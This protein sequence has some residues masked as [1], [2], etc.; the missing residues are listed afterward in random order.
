MIFSRLMDWVDARLPVTEAYK[1]HMSE[2]YAPKN[3]NFWYFF[4][5]IS[6]FVLVNQL[7]TG[8]WLAMF[9]TPT[10]GF[11]SIA[12]IMRDVPWGWLIR[13][14]HAVG[15]SAF[16]AVVYIHMFRGLLYG[17]YK[18]PREL[19]WIFGML[20]YTF[21]M[22]EGFL[23]YVLPWG[24]MSYW[25]AQVI[26]SLVGA[27]PWHILPFVDG[28][29]EQR[30]GEALTTWVRGDFHLST[31][32]VNKFFALHIVAI[33]IVLLGL[34]VLHL[35]ALH[36]V[37]SNNPDGVEIHNHE[38]ENGIP[39]D[40]I[41]FHPYY[42]VKDSVG[43]IVF[44]L[45]FCAIIFFFPTGGG[46]F[47]ETPNFTPANALHTPPTITPSWYFGPYY[48]ILRATTF[49]LFT[50]DAKSWGLIAMA[51]A[52]AILYLAPWLDRNPVKSIRYKGWISKIC[53]ILFGL[54]FIMLGYLGTQ[55]ATEVLKHIAQVGEVYYFFFFLVVLPFA[56][57]FE[58]AKPVPDRVTGGH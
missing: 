54:D 31:A 5:V 1:K 39:L 53:F 17:S 18:P 13:Y 19:V 45:V 41:P 29:T 56:H 34:V 24:N 38:D 3:F 51:G 35:L 43:V 4:G 21:M 52:I 23:G 25:G 14:L 47:L 49:T 11:G 16:F 20:I 12:Y 33:P 2:Y 48:A 58:R 9:Y 55:E 57:R 8:I 42:T 36:T 46:F 50:I 37:G 22:A 40:G 32:T 7:V 10:D 26:I 6:L 28:H 44:L 15:A 27:I 30:I